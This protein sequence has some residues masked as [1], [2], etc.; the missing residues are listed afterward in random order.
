M[1]CLFCFFQPK[2]TVFKIF[3]G[4]FFKLV[5]STWSLV[6]YSK[7]SNYSLFDIHFKLYLPHNQFEYFLKMCYCIFCLHAHRV[8]PDLSYKDTHLLNMHMFDTRV[9]DTKKNLYEWLEWLMA[10]ILSTKKVFPID[11]Q[12]DRQANISN[13]CTWL[14]HWQ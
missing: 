5:F 2:I 3:L 1:F 13:M 11:K 9:F 14:I 6:K 4:F 12:I 7:I 10:L 8:L